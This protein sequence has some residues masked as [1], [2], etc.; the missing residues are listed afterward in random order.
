MAVSATWTEPSLMDVVDDQVIETVLHW[1]GVLNDLLYL[2]RLLEPTS[3]TNRSGSSRSIGDIIKTDASNDNSYVTTATVNDP[4]ICGV[5]LETTDNLAAGRVKLAA[6]LVTINVTGAVARGNYLA[7]SATAGLAKDAGALKT[8]ATF[9]RAITAF[10]GPGTGSVVAVFAPTATASRVIQ[11]VSSPYMNVSTVA[12]TYEDALNLTI[13]SFGGDL[14]VWFSGY[15][16]EQTANYP[17]GMQLALDDLAYVYTD[18]PCISGAL[19]NIGP[20]PPGHK[21]TGVAAGAHT[22]KF[23]LV[24]WNGFTTGY[25]G[26]MHAMEVAP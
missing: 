8:A 2:G 21:F 13:T 20:T 4:N 9:A 3:L 11:A 24:N 7:A 1:E 14:I 15:T 19:N 23:R 25:K 6:G 22:I 26:S 10:A 18:L 17:G 16:Y 5:V 12:T